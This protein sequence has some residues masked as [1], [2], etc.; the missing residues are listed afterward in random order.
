MTK[1]STPIL[2]VDLPA[3]HERPSFVQFLRG[4]IMSPNGVLSGLYIALTLWVL[5]YPMQA[6][7]LWRRVQ[8]RRD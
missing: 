1:E 7:R 6:G 4:R 8:G 5:R 3:R 2:P